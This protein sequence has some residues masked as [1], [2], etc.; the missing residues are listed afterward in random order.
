VQ[1]QRPTKTITGTYTVTLS[2]CGYKIICNSASPF[3]VTLPSATGY[4]NFDVL[5][6]NIGA[7]AVTCDSKTINQNCA[8]L[9][10]NNAATVWVSTVIDSYGN[11]ITKGNL[12]AGSSKISI[13]G[14]GTSALFGT[15]ASVDVNE[16]NL[17]HN[18]VGGLQG[19]TA[20][21]YYHLTE[22]QYARFG[23]PV[24]KTSTYSLVA[25]DPTIVCDSV[26]AFTINLYAATGTGN[27]HTIKNINSGIITIDGNASE[28]IDG[29]TAQFLAQWDA[30]DI[31]DYASG[32]WII[33]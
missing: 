22:A 2:D 5:I 12:A 32:K 29:E 26:T 16:A 17:T 24:V 27:R 7:G 3:T 14:T 1:K 9:L 23:T 19:G 28:T 8:M 15:G 30:V 4:Y 20:S 31:I 21:Q 11:L 10:S 6:Q 25:T 33:V 18:N 13:G